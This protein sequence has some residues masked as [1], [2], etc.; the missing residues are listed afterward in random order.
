[1]LLLLRF[2]VYLPRFPAS[3]TRL[4]GPDYSGEKILKADLDPGRIADG[5]FDLDVVDHCARP[6]YFAN[7]LE[8]SFAVRPA[9]LGIYCAFRS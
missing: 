7:T 6:V 5:K 8:N 2:L 1:L 3:V 9:S 4:T